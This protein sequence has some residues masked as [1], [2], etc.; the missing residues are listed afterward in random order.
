MNKN[1]QN[2]EFV[3]KLNPNI[4]KYWKIEEHANKPIIIFYDRKKHI[5][6]K[7]LKDFGSE[8]KI[9]YIWSKLRMIIKHPDSVF[10]NKKTN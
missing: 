4:A 1:N 5:I 10:Y 3:G 8:E 9:D 2:Y 6:D 7:H